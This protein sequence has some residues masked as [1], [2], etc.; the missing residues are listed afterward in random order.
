MSIYYLDLFIIC[1][2]VGFIMYNVYN[3]FKVKKLDNC[4]DLSDI[5]KL[6][7]DYEEYLYVE[8]DLEKELE[9][10][11]T[12]NLKNNLTNNLKNNLTNNQEHQEHDYLDHHLIKKRKLNLI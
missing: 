3:T 12:N 11:L 2:G 4:F 6:D 7:A 8:K 9:Q 1:G 5:N 10:N